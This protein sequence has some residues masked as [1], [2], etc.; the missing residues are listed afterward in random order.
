MKYLLRIVEFRLK[1]G[2]QDEMY[3]TDYKGELFIG[4]KNNVTIG[5]IY[6]VEVDPKRVGGHYYRIISWCDFQECN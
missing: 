1:P 5:E 6:P 4:S 2:S 3:Y